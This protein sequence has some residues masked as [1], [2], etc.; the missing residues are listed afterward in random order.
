MSQE[1]VEL[2][3][4][5]LPGPEVD[6]VALFTDDAANAQLAETFGHL[7]DPAFV[8]FFHFPAAPPT[9]TRG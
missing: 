3:R 5:F 4:S 8:C 6:L 1:N 2:V 9:H 7:L